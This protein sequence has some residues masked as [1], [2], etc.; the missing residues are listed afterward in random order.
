MESLS[1]QYKERTLPSNSKDQLAQF[2]TEQKLQK[3]I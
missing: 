2:K 1:I 3:I